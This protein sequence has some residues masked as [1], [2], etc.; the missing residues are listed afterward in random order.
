M[1][2]AYL[3]VEHRDSTNISQGCNSCIASSSLCAGWRLRA[4]AA[5]TASQPKTGMPARQ[6]STGQ[7]Q[8]C[9][10]MPTGMR[11]R[12][13]PKQ[14]RHRSG[15]RPRRATASPAA[16]AAGTAPAGCHA[17][18]AARRRW[19]S[20]PG[21]LRSR[22][23]PRRQ[24]WSQTAMRASRTTSWGRSAGAPPTR[25]QSLRPRRWRA[26]P[27]APPRCTPA[28]LIGQT[29]R[30]PGT[31]ATRGSPSLPCWRAPPRR[32]SS[33]WHRARRG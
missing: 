1:L 25:C 32:G 30:Q 29:R 23:S 14:Q 26:S 11:T 6:R 17:T 4:A 2:H 8:I 21:W 24:A 20:R 19:R 28:L 5:C 3:L 18:A 33:N 15:R 10:I 13:T 9:T 27:A 12:S 16:A 7:A 31:C 22:T